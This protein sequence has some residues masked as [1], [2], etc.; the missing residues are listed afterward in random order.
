MIDKREKK[1][2]KKHSSHHSKK[3]MN[4][5]IKDMKAGLSFRKAHNKAMRKV[6]K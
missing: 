2:L 1:L 4:M 3:H 6:G 5:M